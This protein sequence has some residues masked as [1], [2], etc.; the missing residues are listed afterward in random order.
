MPRFE[1]VT[2]RRGRSAVPDTLPR[3]RRWRR[4]RAWCLVRVLMGVLL[5]HERGGVWG[6]G[7]F[8]T[9]SRRRGRAGETWFPPRTRAEGERWS[10]ALPDLPPN[11][12]ARVADALA[13]VGLRRSHLA[14][15][16]G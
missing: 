11:V 8:P 13:L 3:T 1:R 2:T 4:S 14:D 15:L 7:R 5:A 12:L 6:T 9:L 10:C 16:G